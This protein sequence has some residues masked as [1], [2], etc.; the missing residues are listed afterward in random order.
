MTNQ[1]CMAL[2]QIL[3][4]RCSGQARQQQAAE[5]S[6]APVLAQGKQPF[7]PRPKGCSPQRYQGNPQR[8][9]D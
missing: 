8:R 9:H 5:G 6:L 2:T 1:E 3:G 7:V 4:S